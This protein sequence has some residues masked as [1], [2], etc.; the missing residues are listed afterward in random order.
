M[1]GTVPTK[2]PDVLYARIRW[3]QSGVLMEQISREIDLMIHDLKSRKLKPEHIV[4]GKNICM[5]WLVE[6]TQGQDF[7]MKKASRY[8]FT[9]KGIPV[10][11]CES[12]ILEVLPNA[13]AL[14]SGA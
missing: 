11:V 3:I 7:V 12:E 5:R 14:L 9:H 2:N 10:I 1:H 6:S 4:M 8:D 13:K